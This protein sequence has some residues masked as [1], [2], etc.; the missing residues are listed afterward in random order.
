VQPDHPLAQILYD[1]HN[2][3]IYFSGNLHIFQLPSTLQL[4]QLPIPFNRLSSSSSTSRRSSMH[5]HILMHLPHLGPSRPTLG[6]QTFSQPLAFLYQIAQLGL[7][8]RINH[9]ATCANALL[10]ALSSPTTP[11]KRSVTRLSTNF[12]TTFPFF[13]LIF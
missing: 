2:Q 5:S 7:A 12:F 6:A 9:D 1:L 8:L 4:P 10:H 3:S 13:L 11:N